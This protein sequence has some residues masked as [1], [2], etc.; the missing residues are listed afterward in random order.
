MSQ[1]DGSAERPGRSRASEHLQG[2]SSAALPLTPAEDRRW[3]TLA[4]FGGLMGCLPSLV[5]YLVF[6]DRGPFVAQESK[7]ALNFT[8]PL[9]VLLLAAYVLALLPVIGWIFG[10]AAVL[11]WVVMT[12]AG[13]IAGIEC[14]KGRPYRY[15]LNVRLVH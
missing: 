13:L 3:A 12:L 5:I 10:L 8:L 7:E 1:P 4:H 15:R 2:S 9:T 6:R 11:L 14:N